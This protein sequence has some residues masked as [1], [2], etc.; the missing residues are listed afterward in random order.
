MVQS[1]IEHIYFAKIGIFFVSL[2]NNLYECGNIL[3]LSTHSKFS[4]QGKNKQQLIKG[5]N[6]DKI[7]I[8]LHESYEWLIP[9]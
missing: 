9:R 6:P 4:V 1:H 3:F 5:K 2:D 8:M 7:H